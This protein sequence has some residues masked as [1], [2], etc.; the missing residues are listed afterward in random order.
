M[1][2]E[3]VEIENLSGNEAKIYSI[4]PKGEEHPLFDTFVAEH[5]EDYKQELK[6]ILNRLNQIG[7]T[8]GIRDRFFKYEGDYDFTRKYGNYIWA[9]YDEEE[10]NLR[11]YC[12]K[13]SGIA[14][15]LG[16]GG[17]KDKSV[18]KWQDDPKLSKEVNKIMAYAKCI[19]K[20]L[21]DKE[22]SWSYDGELEGRLKNYDDED[23]N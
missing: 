1:K 15:I 16:G 14:I 11:L 2:Y 18:Q 4:I 20:Q 12:I 23:D 5:I 19:L 6:E 13:F 9:L 21:D 8:V 7:N 22:L 3:I 10:S 17:F